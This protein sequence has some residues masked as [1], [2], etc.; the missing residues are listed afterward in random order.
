[1]LKRYIS[2]TIDEATEEMA[3]FRDVADVLVLGLPMMGNLLQN[4]LDT[5]KILKEQIVPK[6]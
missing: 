5:I 6:L 1:M 2:G 3:K 4:G